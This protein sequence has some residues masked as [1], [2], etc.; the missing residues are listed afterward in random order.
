MSR[1]RRSPRTW[2]SDIRRRPVESAY[3]E[4]QG[5]HGRL[6]LLDFGQ[7]F[8][9]GHP[10]FGVL[11]P[12][13]RHQNRRQLRV[14][15]GAGARRRRRLRPR[16]PGRRGSRPWRQEGRRRRGP[17]KSGAAHVRR[18]SLTDRRRGR[19]RRGDRRWKEGTRG[20]ADCRHRRR[21]QTLR[22]HD[23]DGSRHRRMRSRVA[24]QRRAAG[25]HQGTVVWNRQE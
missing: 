24:V 3:L 18:Q 17:R 12:V 20:G 7:H 1:T 13:F 21:D 25:A 10:N 9:D 16:G 15:L 19:G 2:T 8:V 4:I 6:H 11:L 22:R 23:Q 5:R 14:E